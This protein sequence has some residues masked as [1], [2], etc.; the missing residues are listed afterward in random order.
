MSKTYLQEKL[1]SGENVKTINGQS[2]LGEGDLKVGEGIISDDVVPFLL[3]G[4]INTYR[5]VMKKW[6]WG[7]GVKAMTAEGITQLVDRWFRITRPTSWV[8][9]IEFY[10]PSQS[11]VSTGTKT[12]DNAS[13]VCN[14][15]T[16]LSKGEDNYE[17]LPLFAVTD[18]NFIY[19]STNKR[20]IISDIEGITDGFERDNPN[21]LVGVLQMS[22]FEY[23]DEKETTYEYGISA[24]AISGHDYCKPY[25]EAVNFDD[26]SFRQWVCHA[27]YMSKTI[28]NRLTSYAGVIPTA[29]MSQNVLVDRK[30]SMADGLCGGTM[31]DYDF[32]RKMAF[33]KYGQ[34]TLDGKLQGCVNYNYQYYA[35]KAETGVRRI[36]LSVEQANNLVVGSGV[37]LG[38]YNGS[39]ADRGTG[40]NY[41]ISTN[42]G[43]I[44]TDIE[45]VTIDGVTYGA[46]Y[47]DTP[48]TFD[49]NG[50]GSAVSGNTIISTFHWPNGS[51]DSVLGSDGSPVETTTGK[52]P[53]KLQGIEYSV[54]GY[55]VMADVILN[56]DSTNYYLN[57]VDDVTK[58]SK[59]AITDYT[60]IGTCPKAGSAGWQYIKK[61]LFNAGCFFASMVGGSSS[62][63]T[64]DGFYQDGSATTGTREYL[65]FG[66][67][68]N[69]VASGGLSS[70]YGYGDLSSTR[71]GF[72]AR[73][74]C[75]GNRGEY[76]A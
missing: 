22:A 59:S 24:Q 29:W 15:S 25:P 74:S 62:T 8:G 55:E 53:A 54:G 56:E 69:G 76:T 66:S 34:M 58:H 1:V 63:Y 36:L 50:N 57:I 31:V 42:A 64:K 45:Q 27:K 2:I 35:R 43:C 18:C 12:G 39:S 49:T 44:I 30:N 23:Y 41:S 47:V 73:A 65:A 9:G 21:K 16:N 20:P 72:V 17:G 61:L 75:N 32:I 26:D 68:Y 28:N 46:V 40:A 10:Q 5:N 67:L 7:N 19:D 6:F 37:L 4:T 38:V 70:L 11:S 13:L 52:Y 51:C 48:N 14:P 3:D 33:I 71:W 60:R